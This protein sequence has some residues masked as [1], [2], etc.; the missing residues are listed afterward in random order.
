MNKPASTCVISVVGNMT[1]GHA[2]SKDLVHWEHLVPALWQDKPYDI[3]GVF[4]G[5]ATYMTAKLAES[6]G[7]EGL[8]DLPTLPPVVVMYTG[9]TE[10]DREFQ[11]LAFP[12]NWQEDPKLTDWVKLD[13]NVSASAAES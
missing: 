11:N 1:W 13:A 12:K 7:A 3:N 5:S 10:N 4:S 2:I 8:K 9:I 6:L